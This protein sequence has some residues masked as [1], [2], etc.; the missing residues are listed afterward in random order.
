MAPRSMTGFARAQGSQGAHSWAWEARSVNGKG[1]DLRLRLP[2]GSD[3]LDHPL[4]KA[5]AERFKRGNMTLNLNVTREDSEPGYRLNESLLRQLV[6]LAAEWKTE[7][8]EPARMDG[9]LAMRGVLEPMAEEDEDEAA[10]AVREAAMVTSLL[11]ALDGLV[12]ARAEEGARLTTILLGHLERLGTLRTEAT[13][14][15]ALR[16]EA[17]KERMR[18][19]IAELL[20][21][22]SDAVNSDRLAQE[23]ALLAVKGD[24]REELDRLGA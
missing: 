1:L 7:G 19:Q 12:A 18:R 10:K 23:L 17:V 20:D 22:P 3:A 13:Q 21:T 11:E 14:M 4:R 5:V 15:E 8:V 24:I 2:P 16:P 9:L 6:A